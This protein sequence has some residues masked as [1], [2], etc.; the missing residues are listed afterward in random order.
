MN[1]FAHRDKKNG[2]KKAELFFIICI[3]LNLVLIFLY[4]NFG[5]KDEIKF[6]TNGKKLEQMEI[7]KGVQ[8]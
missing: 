4:K 5:L 2:G 8:V 3:I 7:G 1:G 6:I